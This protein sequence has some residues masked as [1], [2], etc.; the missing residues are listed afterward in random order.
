M[1]ISMCV[2]VCMSYYMF[3]CMYVNVSVCMYVCMC[4]YLYSNFD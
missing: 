4:A 3:D 2:F 1:N